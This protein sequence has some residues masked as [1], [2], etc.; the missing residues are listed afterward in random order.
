MKRKDGK[1]VKDIDIYE[2]L[3]PVIM[4]KRYDA[5][6]YFK[7]EINLN[8]ISKFITEEKEKGKN[9]TIMQVIYAAF[10]RTILKYPK[11]NRF[12][13]NGRIYQRN[14]IEISMTVKPRKQINIPETSIKTK[15]EKGTIEEVYQ[16][17]NYNI[18]EAKKELRRRK[19]YTIFIQITSYSFK[20]NFWIN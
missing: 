5:L 7:E 6:V 3:M 19:I 20:T 14:D 1:R 9:Y 8:K 17:L 18:D 12:V 4:K 13:V 16:R 10:V 2:K 15:F 11:L